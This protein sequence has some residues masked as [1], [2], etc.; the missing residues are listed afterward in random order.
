MQYRTDRALGQKADCLSLAPGPCRAKS[1]TACWCRQ[2]EG[3]ADHRAQDLMEHR[4]FPQRR[5]PEWIQYRVRYPPGCRVSH[6]DRVRDQD[7]SLSSTLLG[8]ATLATL[9]LG[10]KGRRVFTFDD[11][12][13]VVVGGQTRD[14]SV[15]DN[16]VC[17]RFADLGA[18]AVSLRFRVI[19][20]PLDLAR[21]LGRVVGH[22]DILRLGQFAGHLLKLFDAGKLVNV[23][24]AEA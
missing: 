19:S 11:L 16:F 10:V 24:Q 21:G 18:V 4:D 15:D 12:I 6:G 13:G 9:N 23:F 14:T 1:L 5:L 17:H 2:R 8:V 20:L 22:G 3:S 7:M